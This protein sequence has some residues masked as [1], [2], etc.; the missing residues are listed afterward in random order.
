MKSTPT[1]A[2]NYWSYINQGWG[3]YANTPSGYLLRSGG[4][5]AGGFPNLPV[6]ALYAASFTNNA[7]LSPVNGNNTYSLTFLPQSSDSS[8]PVTGI[9]PPLALNSDTKTPIGFWSITLYQPDSS[10][11]A[12]PFISQASVLNT[13]YSHADTRVVAI[14]PSTDMITVAA[15]AVGPLQKMTAILFGPGASYYGLSPNVPYY[16]ASTPTQSGG[17]FSFQISTQWKQDLSDNDVPIQYSGSPQGIV[18]LTT[19]LNPSQ[20]LDYGVIQP[21]SQ[22]GFGAN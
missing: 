20:P 3:T 8:L 12:A 14:D 6:D 22:F 11:A 16:I 19:P 21:V 2:T 5:I 18:T 17:N 7:S 9:L 13:A 1:A 10:Q 15:S 4:V